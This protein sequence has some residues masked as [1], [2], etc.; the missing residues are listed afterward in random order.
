MDMI[1]SS[2]WSSNWFLFKLFNSY[3]AFSDDPFSYNQLIR[4][5]IENLNI[6][7]N[8]ISPVFNPLSNLFFGI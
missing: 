5:L 3:G 2:D 1:N 8:Y 6:L 4:L 7:I